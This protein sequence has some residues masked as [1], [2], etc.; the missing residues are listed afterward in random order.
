MIAD[1]IDE[2]ILEVKPVPYNVV[3]EDDTYKGEI[4]VGLKFITNVSPI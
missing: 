2:G 3:L 4:K 1:G